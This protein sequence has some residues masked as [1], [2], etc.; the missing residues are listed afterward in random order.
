MYLG[1][2]D[3]LNQGCNHGL[4]ATMLIDDAYLVNWLQIGHL[5]IENGVSLEKERRDPSRERKKT[6]WVCGDEKD[7]QNHCC[8]DR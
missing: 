3:Q 5:V 8:L 1:S 7:H 6:R 2:R 4:V